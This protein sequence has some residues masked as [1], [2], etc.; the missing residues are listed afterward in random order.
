MIRHALHIRNHME[1]ACATG[2]TRCTR[3][4]NRNTPRAI[5]CGIWVSWALFWVPLSDWSCPPPPDLTDSRPWAPQAGLNAGL[6]SMHCLARVR[7]PLEENNNK[8][9]AALGPQEVYRQRDDAEMRY[10]RARE[11]GGGRGVEEGKD[12]GW[13][14][15]LEGTKRVPKNGGRK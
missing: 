13:V 14:Q 4:R 3:C 9:Y 15:F 2:F 12:S 5:V 6:S 1:Y 7:R 8:M 10:A 11:L